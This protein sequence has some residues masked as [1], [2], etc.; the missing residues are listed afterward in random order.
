MS[1]P[2]ALLRRS[3]MVWAPTS[4]VVVAGQA[5]LVIADPVPLGTA[6]FLALALISWC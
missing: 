3:A 4:V 5:G 2:L 6:G 1:G